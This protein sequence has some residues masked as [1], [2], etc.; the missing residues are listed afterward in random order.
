MTALVSSLV[1]IAMLGVVAAAGTGFVVALY[2]A[3]GRKQAD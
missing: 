2:R 1:L 3:T